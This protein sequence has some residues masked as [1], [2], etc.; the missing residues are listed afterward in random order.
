MKNSFEPDPLEVDICFI[1]GVQGY[2]QQLREKCE[3]T[4]SAAAVWLDIDKGNLSRY[5][6]AC[7]DMHTRTLIRIINRYREKLNEP[8]LPSDYFISMINKNLNERGLTKVTLANMLNVDPSVVYH[9][10]YSGNILV[11]SYIRG[12]FVMGIEL[13]TIV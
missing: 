8:P 13:L 9:W 6:A 3:M 11:K 1:R 2:L 10:E 5:E 12:C 4:L 7:T